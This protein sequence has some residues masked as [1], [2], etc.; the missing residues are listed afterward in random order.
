MRMPWR[1]ALVLLLALPTIAYVQ[2]SEESGPN[3]NCETRA[4]ADGATESTKPPL[5]NM[6]GPACRIA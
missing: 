4:A 1:R 5:D 2:P 3:D 6:E